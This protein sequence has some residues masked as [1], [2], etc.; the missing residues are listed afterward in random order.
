[1]HSPARRIDSRPHHCA[2]A[3]SFLPRPCE[4]LPSRHTLGPFPDHY[5]PHH[6]VPAEGRLPA[7]EPRTFAQA[8]FWGVSIAAAFVTVAA[9]GV[10]LATHLD[11]QWW[12]PLAL[13][14]GIAAAD[15]GSGLVHWGADTWGR[16]DLAVVGPRLLA[17]FRLHHVNPDDFLRRRFLDTNGDVAFVAV[18]VVLA[19][20]ALPLD[21]AWGQPLA[22]FGFAFCGAGMSTN[23]IHQWAHMASPPRA[24]RVLQD[25]GLVLGRV[26]HAVHHARP[27]DAHYC[28][29]T[30]W[31][32]RPLEALDVFRRLERAITRQTGARPRQDDRRYEERYGAR[33]SVPTHDG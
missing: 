1:M 5:L 33:M 29:T 23:Q 28:I 31:C 12:M 30:G 27:Y 21:T 14:A 15:C 19:F 16:D 32:N 4:V 8:A 17:P 7:C 26:E 20:L 11:P 22:V 2:V 24:V 3:S 25:C 13:V 9:S 10:R 18:P 6:P